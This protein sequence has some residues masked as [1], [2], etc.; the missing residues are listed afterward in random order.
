MYAQT[1]S[2]DRAIPHYLYKKSGAL[3]PQIYVLFIDGG[4]RGIRTL[5]TPFEIYTISNRAPS[6]TQTP[7]QTSIYFFAG[8]A[9]LGANFLGADLGASCFSGALATGVD[10]FLGAA[11]TSS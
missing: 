2:T 1:I 7:L 3:A 9:F 10:S 11:L 5:D 8:A 6:T 4:E